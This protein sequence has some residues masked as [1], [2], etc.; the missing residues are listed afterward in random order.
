MRAAFFVP[1]FVVEVLSQLHSCCRWWE[2]HEGGLHRWS[3]PWVPCGHAGFAALA[4]GPVQRLGRAVSGCS[5]GSR[6][7][8]HCPF[9]LSPHIGDEIA[10]RQAAH[11][12]G[13]LLADVTVFFYTN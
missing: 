2:A 8:S 4:V 3:H 11:W 13:G 6:C 12:P 5:L 9:H 7:G 1:R 10:E